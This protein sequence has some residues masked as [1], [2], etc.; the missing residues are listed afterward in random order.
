MGQEK[1][2]ILFRQEM[3]FFEL[4]ST[5]A[6]EDVTSEVCPVRPWGGAVGDHYI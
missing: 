5:V 2:K 3:N 1:N 6:R 4:V